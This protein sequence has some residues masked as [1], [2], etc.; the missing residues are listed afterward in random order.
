M[1]NEIK[2]TKAQKRIWEDVQR[3]A[4]RTECTC[5]L[6]SGMDWNALSSLG[7]GCKSERPPNH[8]A[9]QGNALYICPA[10]DL[11]RREV[12]YPPLDMETG[13]AA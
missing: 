5:T 7:G 9:G 13:E 10:L 1:P 3:V 4:K 6:R 12:G 2:L 11:Y 8:K